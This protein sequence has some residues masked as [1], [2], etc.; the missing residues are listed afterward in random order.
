[1][2]EEEIHNDWDDEKVEFDEDG[3]PVGQFE[4]CD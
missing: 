4:D 1:M 2:D 3:Y